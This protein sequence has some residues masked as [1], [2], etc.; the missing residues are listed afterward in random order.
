MIV[1]NDNINVNLYD[2]SVKLNIVKIMTLNIFSIGIND[3]NETNTITVE[4]P[5]RINYTEI[6]VFELLKFL[7]NPNAINFH[8]YNKNSL[9]ILREGNYKHIKEIF[10]DINGYKVNIGRG[11]SQKAHIISPLE[12]RFFFYLMAICNFNYDYISSLNEFNTITKD[13]YLPLFKKCDIIT[14]KSR[15]WQDKIST[16]YRMKILRRSNRLSSVPQINTF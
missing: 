10:T 14:R 11:S 4:S 2:L 5:S 15:Y 8:L 6:G 16:K 1:F 9:Y 13:R 12:T 7:N 3:S